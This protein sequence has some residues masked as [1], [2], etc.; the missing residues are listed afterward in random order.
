MISY[1]PI[2]NE[3]PDLNKLYDFL[4]R[5]MVIDKMDY[6]TFEKCIS[7]AYFFPMYKDGVKVNILYTIRKLMDFYPESWLRAVCENINV[8]RK[9]ITQKMPCEEIFINFPSL[10]FK[11]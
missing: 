9:R 4:V 5:Y 1:N 10:N 3:G 11:K 6:E 8:T 2:N 7:H